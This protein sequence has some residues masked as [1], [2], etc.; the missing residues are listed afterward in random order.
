M[1]KGIEHDA[2]TRTST[3]VR[4][5]FRRVWDEYY[6][7][8][9]ASSSAIIA[10][11]NT[12]LGKGTGR[13]RQSRTGFGVCKPDAEIVHSYPSEPL[14]NALTHKGEDFTAHSFDDDVSTS[15]EEVIELDIISLPDFRPCPAYEGC[16]LVATNV[17]QGD[18][19]NSMPFIPL[20]DDPTFDAADHCL[21]YDEFAWQ[22]TKVN[23][24]MNA[25]ILETAIRLHHVH[26]ISIGHIDEANIFPRRLKTSMGIWG[27]I[28]ISTQNDI[29]EWPG[30]SRADHPPLLDFTV[31]DVRDLRTRLQ[32]DLTMVCPNLSCIQA[33][34]L[35][36]SL[37][38]VTL[39]PGD[40]RFVHT[41]THNEEEENEV[42]H[43]CGDLCYRLQLDG[44]SDLDV[45]W[46]HS[47]RAELRVTLQ[48]AFTLPPCD[49]AVLCRKPCREIPAMCE[50]VTPKASQ[51]STHTSTQK[52]ADPLCPHEFADVHATQFAPNDPCDH[53]GPCTAQTN[54][55]CFLNK[56]HCTR[57]CRCPLECR[58]RWRGCRCGRKAGKQRRSCL[59]ESCPCRCAGREC[60]PELCVPCYNPGRRPDSPSRSKEA[61][62]HACRNR[63]VQMG[64][65]KR[66]EVRRT[67][68]GMGVFLTETAREGDLIAEY[69]GEL[70]YEPTF[71]T[72]SDLTTH[73]GRNYVY[74]LDLSMLVDGTYAGNE[75]RFINHAPTKKA[76]GRVNI[77]L[78][79]GDHRIGVFARKNIPAGAELFLDYGPEFPI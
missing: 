64:Y 12:E 23:P 42:A 40:E 26:G 74:D 59:T 28:W 58:R 66:L 52:P 73:R 16:T 5:L 24:D 67:E 39:G 50:L 10:T 7:W 36:H 8:E 2:P 35:P 57:N 60:D 72:R 54:C 61:Y 76:N 32:D 43:P 45:S 55:A 53:A 31:P 37:R 33:S 69:A 11:I 68:F 1:P 25:I 70:I 18:D 34:C 21:D 27:I 3:K 22:A 41:K 48:L 46:T 75:T 79:N 77:F 51:D 14:E 47:E 4:L 20:A 6:A 56:A 13:Y 62:S 29:V 15:P 78:V 49:L 19:P 71:Q 17:L 30:S 44:A 9:T 38:Q 65:Q 63:Q